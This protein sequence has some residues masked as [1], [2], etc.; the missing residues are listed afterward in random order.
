MKEKSMDKMVVVVFDNESAA[1]EGVKALR[2][3]HGETSLAL[4]AAAVIAK[5][6]KGA[7][8]VK[9]AADEGPLGTALGL[10]T[11]SL[12]GLLG[13][14]VGL[15]VGA[16]AGSMVGSLYDLAQ[17]GV[18]EDF[19]AE[20]SESLSPGKVA[21]L[22]EVDEEW[23]T[24]LDARMESLGGLVFR[25]ARGEFIDAQIEREIEADRAEIAK[26]KAERDQTVGQ[27]KAKLQAKLDAAQNR[28]EAR[29]DLIKGKIEDI[30]R[31][32]EAKIKSLQ[33]QAVKAK[34]EMKANLEKRVAETRASHQTRVEKLSKA[35]QLV[36]EAAAA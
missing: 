7:V 20:V 34:S 10:T 27:A 21:I 24:P 17:L 4:Y 31:E 11:G 8:T 1:Y 9:Q 5:D 29:R 22:A 15:A 23:V 30:K 18:G 12:V 3:L 28:L 35:W 25:R 36:K 19:L 16:M 2:E 6:A 26:L 13:G 32:G 33:E 14:P